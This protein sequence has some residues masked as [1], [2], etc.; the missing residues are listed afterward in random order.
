MT[1]KIPQ[2]L[3]IY[4]FLILTIIVGFSRIAFAETIDVS[5]YVD[6]YKQRYGTSTTTYTWADEDG[7]YIMVQPA[8]TA[9]SK[10][11]FHTTALQFSRCWSND[12]LKELSSDPT[13]NINDKPFI[14]DMGS[15]KALNNVMSDEPVITD[16]TM[17]SGW[18]VYGFKDDPYMYYYCDS[19]PSVNTT[20]THFARYST[21]LGK[22]L[23]RFSFYV[24]VDNAND[25]VYEDDV[26][27]GSTTYTVFVITRENLETMINMVDPTWL[28]SLQSAE[29]KGEYEWIGVDNVILNGNPTGAFGGKFLSVTGSRLNI[30]NPVKVAFHTGTSSGGYSGEIATWANNTYLKTHESP[31]TKFLT[32]SRM[33]TKYN[34]FFQ[35][36]KRT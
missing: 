18:T 14:H 21:A 8:T 35:F 12:R 29:E 1:K 27:R 5:Q 33:W 7:N 16:T 4:A 17:Y 15:T 23:M 26:V 31:Y 6:T 3:W 24:A 28:S 9:T 34:N 36:R 13:I 11:V 10:N 32:S 19:D 2:T 20:D 25:Y 22:Y 30:Y